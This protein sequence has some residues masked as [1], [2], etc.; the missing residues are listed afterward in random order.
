MKL[1]KRLEFIA[2]HIDKVIAL[3]DIGTDHG[4]IPLYAL[5]NEL[6]EKAIASDINKDPLDKA[7]LNALLEGMGDELEFRLG[8]GLQVL[9]SGEVQAVV[10]AGMGGVLIKDIL[11]KDIKKVDN[12]DYLILQPAQN[13]ELLREYLYTSDYE[14]ISEDLCKDE[15]KYYELFKVKRKAG[16]ATILDNIYYEVSP[17]L[18]M[19]KHPL[20]KEYLESKVEG[21][22]KI[23]GFVSEE[24]DSD[25]A[26]VRKV[27]LEEKVAVI[28]SMINF[29]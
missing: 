26:N 25:S 13:P 27:E 23:L 14:I 17:K 9:K 22:N 2:S 20:I 3:S 29:L 10:I 6:C 18:L 11:E 8:S 21:Y 1:S 24:A 16:E 19:G 15:G 4:Y 5:N 28:S 7:K 12:F